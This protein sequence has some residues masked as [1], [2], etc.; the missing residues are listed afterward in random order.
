MKKINY[1]LIVLIISFAFLT[2]FSEL[3][4]GIVVV[5]K[6]SSIVLTLLFPYILNYLFKIKIEDSLIFVWIIF[7]FLAHYMGVICN[8]YDRWYYFDKV[9]HT[10]SGVL[11]GCVG[12]MILKNIKSGNL[13][14][15]ILF[16]LSFTWMCAGL[17]EV[18]E[19]TCNALFGGDAQKVALT[20]V[21]DTM[22]DMLVAFL[23]S[24]FVSIGYYFKYKK[25]AFV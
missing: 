20:G 24:I 14:F 4:K 11:S 1:V 13:A 22:G 23:G 12:V 3:D 2:I 16:I 9:I 25:C 21:N 15:R 17:W 6:D 5:L 10:F 8:F 18:F 19:F 7:I